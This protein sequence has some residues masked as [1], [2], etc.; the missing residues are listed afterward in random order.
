MTQLT[1]HIT[2][3]GTVL[4]QRV[5]IPENQKKIIV[6]DTL[7]SG[8]IAISE[9]SELLLIAILTKG[10]TDKKILNFFLDG[11]NSRLDFLALIV[12]ENANEFQFET[13]SNHHM[14]HTQAYYHVRAALFDKSKVNYKGNLVIQ[15]NAQLTNTYLA[16]HSL[17]LSKDAKVETIPS[18]EIQA[19]DV[20]AGHAATIG[21]LDEE[22]MFYLQSRGIDKKIAEKLLIKAFMDHDLSLIPDGGTRSVVA[23]GIE[24]ALAKHLNLLP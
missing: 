14:P 23:D 22:A 18:L 12:G 24:N 20:K 10:W 19:D 11:E 1:Q 2:E 5:I 3:F 4:P 6:V 16:H 13:I 8:E 9:N 21:Q 17:M 7:H 15:K